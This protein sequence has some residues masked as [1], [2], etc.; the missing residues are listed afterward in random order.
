MD[1]LVLFDVTH[2]LTPPPSDYVVT[3]R[4][5]GRED[6]VTCRTLAQVKKDV[7]LTKMEL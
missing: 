4:L 7:D 2:S 5:K 6:T 3:G 1:V